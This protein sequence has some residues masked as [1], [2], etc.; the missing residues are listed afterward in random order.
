MDERMEVGKEI[1]PAVNIR[2]EPDRVVLTAEMPGV[3]KE[4]LDIR[5]EGDEVTIE[6]SRSPSPA[7]MRE[8]YR[9]RRADA[10]RRRF[11]LGPSID[12][13][14]IDAQLAEG[15]LT[16]TLRKVKARTPKK[17]KIS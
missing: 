13:S 15:V 9:E 5:V 10:Y 2:E 4:K 1:V 11:V 16:L 8:I 14:G 7:G 17:I 3:E 12:R 6:G